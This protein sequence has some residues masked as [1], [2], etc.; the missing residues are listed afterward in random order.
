MKRRFLLLG[1]SLPFL[2]ELLLFLS[3]FSSPRELWEAESFS[4]CLFSVEKMVSAL[5]CGHCFLRLES[6]VDFF[7][8]VHPPE[9]D[10][11]ML[12]TNDGVF[13]EITGV[14]FLHQTFVFLKKNGFLRW[15]LFE[16]L[17]KQNGSQKQERF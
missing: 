11:G 16:P 15:N 17:Q 1:H 7:I 4:Q 12:A 3:F 5:F 9:G 14:L 2:L 8:S 6:V 10:V 13:V